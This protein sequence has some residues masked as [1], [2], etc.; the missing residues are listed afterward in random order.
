V[1]QGRRSV[2][3]G[4]AAEDDSIRANQQR[5]ARMLI[6]PRRIRAVGVE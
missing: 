3:P 5:V 2:G 4:S 6:E 1:K